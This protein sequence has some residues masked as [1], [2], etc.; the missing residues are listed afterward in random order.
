MSDGESEQGLLS[1]Y[2]FHCSLCC[3]AVRHMPEMQTP[4]RRPGQAYMITAVHLLDM[5]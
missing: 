4:E 5:S 3:T 2:W 1:N